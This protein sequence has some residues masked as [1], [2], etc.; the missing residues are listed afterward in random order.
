MKEY[1]RI[2]LFEYN[3]EKLAMKTIARKAGVKDVQTLKRYY[4]KTGDIYKAIEEYFESKIEYNGEKLTLDAIAKKLS[5]AY[6]STMGGGCFKK[7]SK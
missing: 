4:E 3:G 1:K 5:L 7:V 6:E 2:A